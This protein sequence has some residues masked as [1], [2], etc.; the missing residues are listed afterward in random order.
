MNKT[1]EENQKQKLRIWVLENKVNVVNWY[2]S[3]MEDSEVT[4]EVIERYLKDKN[5]F[6]REE[7]KY[8]KQLKILHKELERTRIKL[9]R[10]YDKLKQQ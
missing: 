5:Q 6:K 8:K 7:A 2:V 3:V 10:T 4:S 1:K 9:D